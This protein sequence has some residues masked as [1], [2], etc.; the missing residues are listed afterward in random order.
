MKKTIITLCLV[1]TICSAALAADSI[2]DEE[3]MQWFQ[4]DKFGMFV[5]WGPY[6]NLAGEWN[7]QILKRGQISE[8]QTQLQR[9]ETAVDVHARNW[10]LNLGSP[11]TSW[12]LDL[13]FVLPEQDDAEV[14]PYQDRAREQFQHPGGSR[15]GGNVEVLRRLV[16][17][18][19]A[20][21]AADKVG[22]ITACP[23][24]PGD[25]YGEHCRGRVRNPHCRATLPSRTVAHPAVFGFFFTFFGG[26]FSCRNSC[27]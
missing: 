22:L 2:S 4:H 24:L 17:Q 11:G 27:S 25:V 10:Y 19:V 16:Q 21:A 6:S 20:D 8:A 18:D 12:C 1:I 23:E 3:R 7:G 5:H 13:G 14:S 9:A 15:V 26:A